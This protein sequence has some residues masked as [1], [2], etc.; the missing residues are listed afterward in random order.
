MSNEPKYITI[1]NDLLERIK[2]GQFPDGKLPSI[3]HL[4]EEY[5]VSLM[6]ANQ[7]VKDLKNSGIVM[8]YPDNRGT[9]IIEKQVN[10]L[11]EC[12]DT[13]NL[14][15][16]IKVY[17]RKKFKIRYFNPE[18]FS[19]ARELW[20]GII[21]SFQKRYPW[22]EIEMLQE[23]DLSSMIDGN[24]YPDVVQLIGRDVGFWQKK[25][26][27]ISL[28]EFLAADSE[29]LSQIHPKA[30]ENS[31][32]NDEVF[33]LPVS[34]GVP[35]LFYRKDML[36]KLSIKSDAFAESGWDE[37]RNISDKLIGKNYETAIRLG[38]WSYWNLLIGNT[39]EEIFNTKYD[40]TLIESIETLKNLYSRS[41]YFLYGNGPRPTDDF[42]KSKGAI[43][44]S[45]SSFMHDF[46][47]YPEWR[48][49]GIPLGKT[50]ILTSETCANC[51]CS[52]SR[53]REEAWLFI[54]YLSSE[55]VQRKIAETRNNFPVHIGLLDEI[56]KKPEFRNI[57]IQATLKN[58]ERLSINTQTLYILYE[59]IIDPVLETYF[60]GK[61]PAS[62]VLEII[63]PRIAE[64]LKVYI[65]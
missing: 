48:I 29:H 43:F 61:L 28:N 39:S 40:K 44:L 32:F 52:K 24:D 63:R 65:K 37:L 50:G 14:M 42:F 5:N 31:T 12:K 10:L 57:N 60:A 35:L 34:I 15:E 6:T 41:S 59:S 4:A 46:R 27:I 58:S 25:G 30:L 36:D 22:I 7:T 3:K 49:A 47:K 13:S 19:P 16:N 51:I 55:N 38:L 21:E 9:L 20:D 45:Y 62:A 8:S 64:V 2:Q 18:Y 56:N 17:A 54:K 23:K 11:R 26:L 53:Q 1:R 33:A